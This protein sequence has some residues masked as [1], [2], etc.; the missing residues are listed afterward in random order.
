VGALFGDLAVV[1][2][3]DSVGEGGQCQVVGDH[4]CGLGVGE[5]TQCWCEC[6]DGGGVESGGGFVEDQHW[7]VAQH[8]ACQRDALVL[9]SRQCCAAVGMATCRGYPT[10]R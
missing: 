9:A 7:C 5:G 6:G 10:H 8:G 3:G 1:E 4:D 2:Y